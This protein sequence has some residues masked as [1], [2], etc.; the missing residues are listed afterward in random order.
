MKVVML[1]F[2][3]IFAKLKRKKEVARVIKKLKL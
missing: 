3:L 1:L 2:T